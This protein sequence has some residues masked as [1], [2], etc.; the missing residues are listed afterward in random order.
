MPSS[1]ILIVYSFLNPLP[2]NVKRGFFELQCNLNMKMRS[3]ATPQGL[4]EKA[5]G[6]DASSQR[7]DWLVK[8]MSRGHNHVTFIY[9][10]YMLVMC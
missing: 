8:S 3:Y 5:L 1:H 9:A 4:A 6:E 7:F 10:L 2:S